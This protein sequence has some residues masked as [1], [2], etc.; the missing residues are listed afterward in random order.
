G[1]FLEY[2]ILVVATGARLSPEATEGLTG[3]GWRETA[4]DFY[5]LEG[6]LAL[7]EKL[8]GFE[9]GRVLI[10]VVHMPIKCLVAPLEFAFLADAFFKEK[11]VWE[12][13]ELRFV[14]LL[15]GAFTK[16]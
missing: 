13:I 14:T 11:G 16:L 9:S 10:N 3:H 12:D 8:D 15:D 4:F 2:E 7:A 1:S 6:V 5:S